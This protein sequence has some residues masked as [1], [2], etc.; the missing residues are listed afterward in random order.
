MYLGWDLILGVIFV[1]VVV[2][3]TSMIKRVLSDLEIRLEFYGFVMF[4]FERRTR[5]CKGYFRFWL[6]K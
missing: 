6:V 1:K 5:V 2:E 3:L 4:E